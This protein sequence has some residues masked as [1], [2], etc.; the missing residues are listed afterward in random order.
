MRTLGR[1]V[2]NLQIIFTIVQITVLISLLS[3]FLGSGDDIVL[4]RQGISGIGNRDDSE[5]ESVTWRQ[6]EVES[7]KSNL[8]KIERV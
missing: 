4:L 2:Q 3:S 1:K 7:R 6:N 8:K 5:I